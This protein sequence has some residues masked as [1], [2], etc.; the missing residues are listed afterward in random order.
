[1]TAL[2]RHVVAVVAALFALAVGIAIGGGPLSYVPDR[3]E[4]SSSAPDDTG[5]PDDSTGEP[6]DSAT[7]EFATAF[8][9]SVAA[10]VYAGRLFGHP[11]AIVAMPGADEDVVDGMIAQVRTAGGGLTGVFELGDGVTDLGETSL[12]DTLGSQLVEQ[13]DTQYSDQT[14]D[15]TAPTYVRLGQLIGLA[16][17]TPVKAGLRAEDPEVAVRTALAE[18][19]LMTSPTDA[20]LAPLVIA[21]L[22]PHDADDADLRVTASVY[23]GLTI[24]L[25]DN[26]AGLV[27]LGDLASG[28]SGIL[29][30]MRE[31]EE[32]TAVVSTVDGGDTGIGQVTAM[33]ATIESLGESVGSYGASGS[34]GAAP[35]S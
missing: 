17:A 9:A 19:D 33:L 24:G 3:D 14:V 22:P 11:T 21:I 5:E 13:L 23:R 30:E 27:V 15:P 1:V 6:S 2:K 16:V 12:V 34:D 28:R 32:L 4:P 29:A 31:D 8:A 25:G 20:R 26:P 10:T 7:D 35:I 18:A